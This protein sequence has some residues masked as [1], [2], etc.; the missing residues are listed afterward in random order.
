M[1]TNQPVEVLTL[2]ASEN[3]TY[4]ID[5][6]QFL[7][8][9]NTAKVPN[10]DTVTWCLTDN[11]GNVINSREDVP[12]T[13]A[14]SMTILLS[15]DDL[16]VSGEPDKTIIRDGF[17]VKIYQRRVAVRGEI[18]STLGNDNPVTKEFAFNIENIVCL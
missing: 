18:D 11:D 7:D 14:L 9:T 3:G 6:I 13:S 17:L 16:Q 1:A 5:D 8:E 2:A 10:T 15:G 4:P 12:L